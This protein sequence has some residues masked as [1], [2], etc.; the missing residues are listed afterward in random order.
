[1]RA[2]QQC[3]PKRAARS[4]KDKYP[5]DPSPSTAACRLES[6]LQRCRD[7]AEVVRASEMLD[8]DT[9]IKTL[10]EVMKLKQLTELNR[11]AKLKLRRAF[12]D[13]GISP[14]R[15]FESGFTAAR[16]IRITKKSGRFA[17]KHY[18]EALWLAEQ[19]EIKPEELGVLPGEWRC[20]QMRSAHHEQA[21]G[22][23][24]RRGHCGYGEAA[25]GG[26]RK[27]AP[28]LRFESRSTYLVISS[29]RCSWSMGRTGS[30]G[31]S[32]TIKFRTRRRSSSWAP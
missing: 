3:N 28:V 21:K 23:G 30:T 22:T 10:V 16:Q 31:C 26:R 1:M 6:Q 11:E 2:R 29:M 17:L 20:H 8:E 4:R 5:E 9:L 13:V 7:G 14:A 18:A 27:D 32:A 25:P 19:V 12:E 15:N 24:G